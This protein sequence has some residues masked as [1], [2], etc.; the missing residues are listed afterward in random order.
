[1]FGMLEIDGMPRRMRKL[2]LREAE[3]ALTLVDCLQSVHFV[4]SWR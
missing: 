3:C 1:M 2:D 4:I